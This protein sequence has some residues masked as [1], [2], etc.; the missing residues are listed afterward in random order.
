MNPLPRREDIDLRVREQ[1]G[2]DSSEEIVRSVVDRVMA[3]LPTL[4]ADDADSSRQLLIHAYG[5]NRPGV[6]AAITEVLARHTCDIVDISLILRGGQ[7]ALNLV[8]DTPTSVAVDVL[9]EGLGQP[10]RE[11]EIRVSILANSTA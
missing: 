9:E 10:A 6:L 7:F 8:V 3:L 4:Q 2:T 1:L 5:R 11:L